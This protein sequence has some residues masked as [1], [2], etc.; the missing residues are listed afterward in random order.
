MHEEVALAYQLVQQFAL[1]VRDRKG[2]QLDIW[3]GAVTQSTLSDLHPFVKGIRS[4]IEAVEA[5]LILLMSATV[6]SKEKSTS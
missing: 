3:L 5:G 2:G 1:M 4:D 6:L